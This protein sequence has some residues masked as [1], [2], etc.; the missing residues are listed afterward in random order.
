M[1]VPSCVKDPPMLRVRQ[2]AGNRAPGVVGSRYLFRCLMLCFFVLGLASSA[3][4]AGEPPLGPQVNQFAPQG[5]VKRVRQA[6]AR[7]SEPMVPVG[8]PRSFVDPFEIECSEDGVGR[9]I[10]SHTWVY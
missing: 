1:M 5:T 4:K 10:D 9:W 3:M 8:D 6:S 7:F 2:V